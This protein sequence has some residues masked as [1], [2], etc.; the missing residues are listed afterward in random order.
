[1][2]SE[3][4]VCGARLIGVW[5][6]LAAALVRFTSSPASLP[7]WDLDPLVQPRTYLGLTP[8][9]SML[10]DAV[11]LLGAALVARTITR[12]DAA[13]AWGSLVMLA[14][15]AAPVV[16]HA[17]V[18][19]PW[20][21]AGGDVVIRGDFDARVVGFA[22]L[23]AGASVWAV[24]VAASDAFV[25]RALL[26]TLAGFAAFP[27]AEALLQGLV[28]LPAL[29]AQVLAE[30]DRVV[31]EAGYQPGSSSA[32]LL[33]RKL[34]KLDA[35][36][37]LGLAN[38]FGV[39]MAALLAITLGAGLAAWRSW[40]ARGCAERELAL[41]IVLMALP[42]VGAVAAVVLTRSK[43][44]M[45]AAA[46]AMVVIPA[47]HFSP[48]FGAFLLRR[49]TSLMLGVA[50]LA[51][52]A[53]G[54]R[55]TLGTT[56]PLGGERSLLFRSFYAGAA[57][58]LVADHGVL[59]VGPGGFQ[60]AYE[61]V[62]PAAS[63]ESAND[64]HNAPLMH[65][66]T[67]GVLGAGFVGSVVVLAVRTRPDDESREHDGSERR[68]SAGLPPEGGRSGRRSSDARSAS[69][70]PMCRRTLVVLLATVGVV[71]I[72]HAA[73]H[74]RLLIAAPLT[75]AGLAAGLLVWT[76]VGV[77]LVESLTP[78]DA[79]RA[80]AE[81]RASDRFARDGTCRVVE[82]PLAVGVV[83]AG[84]LIVGHAMIDVTL[85]LPAAAGLGAVLL[86]VTLAR[87]S[88]AAGA[89]VAD[90]SADGSTDATGDAGSGVSREAP[91]GA[92]RS[93][94]ATPVAA[95]ILVGVSTLAI[96]VVVPAFAWQHRLLVAAERV[97][98][99]VD[100]ATTAAGPSSE[101]GAAKRDNANQRVRAALDA[102]VANLRAVAAERPA[103]RRTQRLLLDEQHRLAIAT[104][105]SLGVRVDG[106]VDGPRGRVAAVAAF[107][108]LSEVAR[109]ATAFA[110]TYPNDGAAQSRA[111]AVLL[112]IADAGERLAL[113]GRGG[114]DGADVRG[115]AVRSSPAAWSI[116]SSVADWRRGALVVA[117]RAVE[118]APANLT[119]AV[120]WHAAATAAGER[121]EAARAAG[122]ALAV[123]A[124]YALD[125]AAQLGASARRALEAAASDAGEGASDS[126]E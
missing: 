50:A 30:A 78:N 39:T 82:R 16:L 25:R 114:A 74:W 123:D 121:D 73:L 122:H 42:V 36:G 38:P 28:E 33:L 56:G 54:F 20:G 11:A 18:L 109:S 10:L 32:R 94:L 17:F 62:K 47:A 24:A 77:V 85:T 7:G 98:T 75:T 113:L 9:V 57:V 71:A 126:V 60:A 103:F 45:L 34:T 6:V 22:W 13:L 15:A 4:R 53:L 95:A 102:A 104:V 65:L 117:R 80:E 69:S 79:R 5:L 44:A 37:W 115:G 49:R 72:A 88:C 58:E 118:A 35:T 112:D 43:A 66:A 48:R 120:R 59:G 21:N 76:I 61:S 106:A 3:E 91:A 110:V 8:P 14:L 70:A 68:R 125:P 29:R 52:A 26:V 87:S 108:E 99:A 84:V 105:S 119:A 83:V 101:F 67:L 51:I 81:V 89:V 111:A 86:G 64:A 63:A 40:R 93:R 27:A 107:T 12:R 116:R 97:R 92:R 31:R 1:M 19:R 55:A 41:R 124:A 100:E 46:C 23:S 96:G 2:M 90:G